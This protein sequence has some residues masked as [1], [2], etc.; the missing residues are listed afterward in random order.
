MNDHMYDLLTAGAGTQPYQIEEATLAVRACPIR[1][2]VRGLHNPRGL[3][4]LPD[5]SLL[6]AEAGTGSNPDSRVIRLEPWSGGYRFAEVVFDRQPSVNILRETRR[7]EIMGANGIYTWGSAMLGL[8]TDYRHGASRMLE[9]APEPGRVRHEL[10]GHV[11]EF[12]YDP[13][14]EMGYTVSPDLDC[15]YQL[16]GEG[17]S[18]VWTVLSREVTGQ[19]PGQHA[20][21]SGI[22]HDP[23]SGTLLVTLLSGEVY[24]EPFEIDDHP[25]GATGLNFL[26]GLARVLAIDPSEGIIVTHVAGLTF[27]T[28][29]LAHGPHLFV[30]EG[31]NAFLD[32]LVREEHFHQRRHGG[33]RRFSGRL[34]HIDRRT[35]MASILAEQLDLP[36]NL[37]LIHGGRLLVSQGAGIVGRP[38]PGPNGR[39]VLLDGFIS[40]IDVS[41]LIDGSKRETVTC[42]FRSNHPI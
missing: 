3:K 27:A 6:V 13:A 40:E 15:V 2:V 9:I 37:S 17:G 19:H 16:D 26:H 28:A 20:V 21:P 1:D 10:R 11:V 23:W 18:T 38:I 42:R 25:P 31:C 41:D 36:S 4:Q 22:C 12:A 39:T 35:G 34:L 30:L 29:T 14:T 7:E 8:F 24:D 32:P 5:G 33:Y